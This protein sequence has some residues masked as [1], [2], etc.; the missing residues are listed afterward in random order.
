LVTV[1]TETRCGQCASKVL[2]GGN[3]AGDEARPDEGSACPLTVERESG[4][5]GAEEAPWPPILLFKIFAV[6]QLDGT[7][8][9][10]P[11][12]FIPPL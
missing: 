9:S 11:A 10:P 3:M 12:A 6:R 8:H 7:L 5:S 2:T 1:S 4:L